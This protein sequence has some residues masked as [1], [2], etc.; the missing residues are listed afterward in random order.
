M[1]F[2]DRIL[3]IIFVGILLGAGLGIKTNWRFGF[4]AKATELADTGS[5]EASDTED[6]DEDQDNDNKVG[7]ALSSVE[8]NLGKGA[9]IPVEVGEVLR[10]DLVQKISAQGR[11]FTY[12]QMDVISE[13]SARL[14][15]IHFKDGQKVKKGQVIAELDKR[16]YELALQEAEANYLA[17]MADYVTYDES[18]NDEKQGSGI[19]E[20]LQA[21][22]KKMEKG[23]ISK[24]VYRQES[25][26]LEL[27]QVRSGSRRVEVIS[28]RT[29]EQ[30]KVALERAR[31]NLE[32]CT[33]TAPFGGQLF[34]LSV[35]EGQWLGSSTVV[36]KIVNTEDVVVKARVLESEM[37]GIESG[38]PVS[39]SF[40][41]L[42][43]I[44]EIEGVVESVSPIVNEEDK[45]VECF[46][47]FDNKAGRVK[48]GMFA[49]TIIDS[50]T[51]SD[52]LMVP[53]TAILPRDDRKVVFKVVEDR[54]AWEY[55]KTGVENDQFVQIT[56]GKLEPGDLVLTNNHFTMGHATK[57]SVIKR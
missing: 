13:I 9:P 47:R 19:E 48:P 39:I 31:I 51:F 53:K 22:R 16:E 46:I 25:F 55:V 45:T 32:K 37:G 38:R 35:V 4:P 28:A 24:E 12:K 29:L 2:D 44:A 42:K 3:A 1:K 43:D 54:A 50:K 11:V 20:K 17:A 36:A 56:Q 5:P 49:E 30:S 26:M 27:D 52:V 34:S 14:A 33:I 7:K 40:P 10:G 15:K 6:E 8:K 21:L 23:E 57:V 41:A 18:L